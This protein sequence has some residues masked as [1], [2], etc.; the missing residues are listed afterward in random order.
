MVTIEGHAP[1]TSH[2]YAVLGF[3]A[4]GARPKVYVQGGLHA[5]EGPGM[6]TARRL[7]ERL[8]VL[9][10][11]GRVQGEVVL[12]PCANPIGLAQRLL[13]S[14]PGRFDL[15]DGVNFNRGYPDLAPG[16]AARV[17][18][19]LGADAAENVRL[20]RAALVA[21]LAE[22]PAVTPAERLKLGLLGAAIDADLVLDLHCDGEAEVHL[23][24]LT[25]QAEALAP[26]A[27]LLGARAVLTATDS[28]HNPFDEATSRP[29][30]DLA[31]A[32]P[33]HPVPLACT[34][35]TLELRGE[36]DVD[37][38]LAE[39]DAEAILGYL[40]H[41]GVLEG[42]GPN[43]PPALCAPTPLEATEPLV[44]PA[45]GLV[46]YAMPLGATVC[47]GDL[48]AEIVDPMTGAATAVRATTAG[49]LFARAATR[50]AEAGK[51]L[52]KIAGAEPLRSG[53]LLSP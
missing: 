16:V 26:L 41:M 35:A 7:V 8:A 45:S 31:R 38:G 5:D 29:W 17:A 19:R 15:Y 39:A 11:E 34:A 30:L 25:P 50:I 4:E 44:A 47:P 52:G 27:A 48:V 12:V 51:R 42:P 43:L 20:I 24:T 53:P 46:A 32:F 14:H 33:G 9:E 49:V 23:Y 6:L 10:A 1:G 37:R 22:R 40:A 36:A 13:A 28:G 3:G 2:A 21:E 18:G